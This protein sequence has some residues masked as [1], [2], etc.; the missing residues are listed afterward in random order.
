VPKI[1]ESAAYST[2]ITGPIAIGSILDTDFQKLA[3]Q[4]QLNKL[5]HPCGGRINDSAEMA[6]AL[7][8]PIPVKEES[9]S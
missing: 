6:R 8:S 5:Q 4:F 3:K 9:V 2:G 1:A 7:L